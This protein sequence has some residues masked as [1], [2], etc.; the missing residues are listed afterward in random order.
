MFK[1]VFYM[2]YIKNFIDFHNFV[3]LKINFKYH[4]IQKRKEIERKN[5]LMIFK[6]VNY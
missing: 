3:L 1:Y 6:N 5:R 2:N 4:H